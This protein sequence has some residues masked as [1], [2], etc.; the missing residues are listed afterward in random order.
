LE[1]SFLHQENR[2]PTTTFLVQCLIVPA[3]MLPARIRC[4]LALHNSASPLSCQR[5]FSWCVAVILMW[6]WDGG[7]ALQAV[8]R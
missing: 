1:I 2:Q 4:V 5:A 7:A 6:Q 8:I 3:T